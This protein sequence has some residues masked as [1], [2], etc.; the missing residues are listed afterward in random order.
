VDKDHPSPIVKVYAPI[1]GVIVAQNI[2][3]AA[4]TGVALFGHG[5]RPSPSPT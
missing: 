4:A 2:T 3:N 1:S 5:Q